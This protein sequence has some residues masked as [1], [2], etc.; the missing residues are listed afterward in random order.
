M[1]T[2]NGARAQGRT[3][4]GVIEVGKRADFIVLDLDRPHPP[5]GS[6]YGG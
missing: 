3:D 5:A 4:C 2:V 6:Q 1:A